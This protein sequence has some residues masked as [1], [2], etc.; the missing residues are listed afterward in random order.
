MVILSFIMSIFVG[1]QDAIIQKFTIRIAGGYISSITGADVKI[2]RLYISP[3]FTIQLD[4]FLVKDLQGND[5]LLVEKL[6]VR[7]IMEDIIHGGIHVGRVEMEDAHANLITYEGEDHLNLQ[8][9]IDAFSTGEKEKSDKVTPIQVDR[10]LLKNLNFQF[11]DQNKEDL[12]KQAAKEMDYAHLDLRNINLDLEDLTVIGDS[13]HGVIHHLA[14]SES[15]G[16]ELVYLESEVTVTSKEILLDQLKL[17]T[18]DSQL[19]L[20]LQFHYPSFQAFSSFVDSVVLDA[21]IRP[22]TLLLSELGPFAKV[23]YEMPD[24]FKFQGKVHGPVENLKLNNLKL[25]YG[26]DTKLE[27]NLNLHVLDLLKGKQTIRLDRLTFSYDDLTSLRLP[28][29]SGTLPIPPSLAAIGKGTVK[30]NFSGTLDRFTTNLAI[31]TDIGNINT[32]LNRHFNE[33]DYSVIEGNIDA[34]RLNL[35]PI[36]N[37]PDLLGELDLAAHVIGRQAKGGDMDLDIEGEISDILL[38]GNTIDVIALNGNLYKNCFNGRIDI[39][40]DDLDF[41]FKGRFDFSNPQALKGNFMADINKADLRKLQ[42]LKNEETALLSASI[43]ANGS[44]FN[45][46]NKAEGTLSIKDLSFTNSKGNLVMKQFDGAIV[47][48]P[49]LQKRI[50]LDCDFFDFEMGG[51]MDFT[52]MVMAFKQLVNHYVE[53]PAWREELMAFEESGESSEQDFTLHLNVNDPKTLTNFFMPNLTIAKNTSLNGTFTSQSNALNL[54]LRSKYINISGIKISNIECKSNNSPRRLRTRLSIDQI[55]LR[56]ST[57]SD[58]NPIS[59]DVFRLE[60]NLQDDSIKTQLG[61][62]NLETFIHNNADIHTT[63][64]PKEQG[65]WFRVNEADIVIN[66]S[67]WT[68]NPRNFVEIDQGRTRISELELMGNQQSLLIDGMVP[69]TRDDT[70]SVGFNQFNLAILNFLLKSA[71]IDVAGY[72]NGNAKVNDLK[73]SKTIFADL[74]IKQLGL[75][76]DTF[77]NADIHSRWNNSTSSI[78]IDLSLTEEEKRKISLDGSYYVNRNKDNLDFK[79][80]LDG[81]EFNLLEPFLSDNLQR[82][83][84]ELTGNL[85]IKGSFDQPDI[86]GSVKLNDGGCKVNLLNTFYTFSPTITIDPKVIALSNFTLTDTLGNTARVSGQISHNYLKDFYLNISLFPTEFLAMATTAAQSSSYYGTA[87]ANGYV[88]AK[89]PLNNIDLQ[90]NALT[91]KGTKITLPL[92]GN[93]TVK[94]QDFVTFI[95]HEE[96]TPDDEESPDEKPKRKKK[97]PN[98]I[99]IGLNL[100]VNN[101]AQIK[102]SLPNN[103]GSLEARG[104]GNIMLDIATSN[105]A[106]SLIGDYVIASGSLTLNIQN[107]LKRNFLLDPGSRI[108]WTGDPINGIIDATGVYQ[109]KASLSSLGLVD[110]TSNSGNSNVKVECLVRLKNKLMNPDI[111]FGLRLPNATEEMRQAVFYAIDTTNQSEV[112][113]QVIS[114]LVFNSF[115]YGTALNGY[116]LIAGQLNDILAQNV[117]FIDINVNYSYDEGMGNEEV[118]LAL[119]KQLFNDRLTIETNF[120]V[121]IPNSTA[122][123]NSGSNIVGD[124]NI[125]FKITKDG[126]FSAQAFNRSNYNNYYTQYT[127]YKMA[128]YTQGIG[129]SYSKSFD[130]FK[131]FFKKKTNFVPSS[132]PMVGRPRTQSKNENQDEPRD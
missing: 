101:D 9:L 82:M 108:S 35:G 105:N 104:D 7:P 75:N 122:Y 21:D 106:M 120:G 129:L 88:S 1:I 3:N 107:F 8:F 98:N 100:D 47:N 49:L 4:H 123:S 99:N 19:D 124:F 33:L 44:N 93:S 70:L 32:D 29:E 64:L 26:D 18:P 50:S 119:K 57:E 40:D 27:G 113:L 74:A 36:I 126:R 73:E 78:D 24:E 52:T 68:I 22:T 51:K 127:F 54:T 132:G 86:R 23:L 65:W 84:G 116:N 110:S 114:L 111:T 10:V 130:K 14:A 46:F 39:D 117:Q 16:F 58:P 115:S 67:L 34:Q 5:L 92:G 43:T 90:I 60:A 41:D 56:D 128:P 95:T 96:A 102:I 48:D 38:M 37:N 63:I 79:L 94:K 109:T 76:G 30:G 17:A 77:G 72:V 83:Q 89:G 131:D 13:I 45:N 69:M 28:G 97:D 121:I 91:K 53:I 85:D 80:Q 62:S 55:L 2:G 66:D 118:S 81:L 71:G 125:D 61:W 15:S 87:I 20:D 42:L 31:T 25:A 11:W 112:L 6:R 12:E 59:L 103:L